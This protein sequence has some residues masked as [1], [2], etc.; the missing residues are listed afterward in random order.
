MTYVH[1]HQKLC[2]TVLKK[3]VSAPQ[4]AIAS[5]DGSTSLRDFHKL[6][7]KN[8]TRW[9]HVTAQLKRT[10]SRPNQEHSPHLRLS[11]DTRTVCHD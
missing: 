4:K 10:H 2:D 3:H 7:D 11:I 6:T 8:F 5:P 9:Q 1:T